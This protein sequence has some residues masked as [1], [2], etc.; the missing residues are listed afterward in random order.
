MVRTDKV[1]IVRKEPE[2]VLSNVKRLKPTSVLFFFTR[3]NLV[4]NSGKIF[5]NS[6]LFLIS[7]YGPKSIVRRLTGFNCTLVIVRV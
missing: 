3:K 2:K 6:I 5:K 7:V 1:I 4:K